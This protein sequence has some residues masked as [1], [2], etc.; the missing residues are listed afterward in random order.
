MINL[1]GDSSKRQLRAARRNVVLRKYVITTMALAIIVALSYGV[2]YGML[3]QQEMTH[4][5]KIDEYTPQKM[6]YKDT[7]DTA[8][9]Y[10]KDLSSAKNILENEL[11]FSKFL[12]TIAA[13]LPGG[14]VSDS[15]NVAVKDFSKPLEL[16]FMAQEYN[17]VLDTKERFEISPYFKEI[18]VRS[19][20]KFNRANYP[21]DFTLIMTFDQKAFIKAQQDEDAI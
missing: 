5:A 3:I 20:D 12:T 2:G 10:A 19:I 15:L 7:I 11:M 21:Y 16:K 4:Q 13:T 1:L 14:V 6:Q 17:N 8:A 9:A 18:K